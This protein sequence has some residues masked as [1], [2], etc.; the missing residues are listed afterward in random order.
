MRSLTANY[1]QGLRFSVAQ[2]ATLRQLG[3]YR[4]RQ[5][6]YERQ[7]PEV[8]AGLRTDAA[9]ESTESSN[10]IEGIVVA[11]ARLDKLVKGQAQPRTRSEQEVAG[12]RDVLNLIHE[13]ARDMPVSVNVVL[14]LHKTIHRYLPGEG[15]HWK[16]TD[17]EIVERDTGGKITRVRF[18]PVTAVA[19]PQAMRD[20]VTD[21]IEARDSGQ[22][23]PLVLV[24]LF[25]LDFLCIHPFTDGNGRVSRL[26]MLQ[27]LYQF[28]YEVGRYISLERI[29]EESKETYYEALAAGSTGWHKNHHDVGPWIDYFWGTLLRA[30]GEF[31]E[32]V[33][34]IPRG[35]GSKG[36]QVIAAVE[37][38]ITPFRISDLEKDCPGVSRERIRMV[39]RQLKEQG[40]LEITGRGP[41]ARWR[42]VPHD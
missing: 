27:L 1:L 11:R 20:L 39:L 29:I 9:I 5:E 26:L 35:K 28:G 22:H 17:N 4:G 8:L 40:K 24:P 10:R 6:L 2:L 12:Y 15:G 7:R 30:H 21:Y 23:E 19:T 16:L 32:R 31:E 34:S 14:Q 13:S 18:K 41:G 36:Q 33:G 42:V 37:R 3:T 38:R 25:L